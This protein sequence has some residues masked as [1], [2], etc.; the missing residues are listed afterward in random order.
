MGS[1]FPVK[2]LTAKQEDSSVRHC[3]KSRPV[4]AKTAGEPIS[5][6]VTVTRGEGVTVFTVNSKEGSTW[7]LLCQ[8]LGTLCYSPACAVSQALRKLQTSSQLALG[9]IQI[10]VGILHISLGAIV[11]SVAGSGPLLWD[12]LPYWFGAVFIVGGIMCIL[13][14]KFPSPCLVGINVL[15][16]LSGVALAITAIVMYAIYLTVDNFYWICNEDYWNN[17][18]YWNRG[19]IPPIEPRLN[20]AMSK[21]RSAKMMAQMLLNGFVI[22]LI[23]LAVLQLCVTISSAVLGLKHLVKSMKQKKVQDLEQY[24]PLLEEVTTNPAA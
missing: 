6:S 15:L 21:Y 18:Y 9:I 17:G 2:N 8:I 20:E 4:E 23:V 13:V 10:M 1:S 3:N 19:T 7:P 22:V 16:N 14:E 5:M 11:V 24:K 12:G